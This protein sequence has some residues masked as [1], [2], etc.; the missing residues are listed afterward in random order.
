[1]GHMLVEK[2]LPSLAT[3]KWPESPEASQLGQK[4]YEVGLD[5][6]DE[7]TND[8]KTLA[9]ALRTFQSGESRPYAFAGASYT[10]LRASRE[11]DGKY[12]PFGLAASLEWLEKAQD[13]APDVVEINMIEA[14]IYIH[15]RRLSDARIILDYLEKIDAT[16]YHVLVAEIAY[17]QEQSK[18]EETVYWHEQAI[19]AA[20]TVP[21][22]LRLRNNLGDVYL[23]FGRNAQA[24][25]V[26]KEAIHFARQNAQLWH[27]MSIAYWREQNYQEA[28]RCNERALS[29]QGDFPEALKMEEALKEKLDSGGFSQ[30]LYGR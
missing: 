23:Q 22:K 30:R 2:M 11:K 28:A 29:L 19:A 3:M 27:K 7:Y 13:L 25:E 1:M 15:S 26:Y 5:K 24:L 12:A 20:D 6:V 16:N 9:S 8:P 4:A 10:L 18:L 21:R 17:W 14:H